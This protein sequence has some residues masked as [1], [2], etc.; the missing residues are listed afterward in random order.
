M[1]LGRLR[2]L[3]DWLELKIRNVSKKTPE[4]DPN[5]FNE[6]NLSIEIL[7]YLKDL[8]KQDIIHQENWDKS[9]GN[10]YPDPMTINDDPTVRYD[11]TT[12]TDYC[13]ICKQPAP[14][15]HKMKS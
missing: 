14:C 13:D 7:N 1:D 2:R 3:R 11:F 10:W 12:S 8:V 5:E 4:N 6:L 15:V 9:F